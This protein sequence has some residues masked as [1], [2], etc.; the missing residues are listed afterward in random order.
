MILLFFYLDENWCGQNAVVPYNLFIVDHHI[1]ESS[2]IAVGIYVGIY[3][4]SVY[5][6]VATP[7]FPHVSFFRRKALL[8]VHHRDFP[9]VDAMMGCSCVHAIYYSHHRVSPDLSVMA[10]PTLV[11]DHYDTTCR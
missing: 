2:V 5:L 11:V 10:S 7:L 9:L 6:L 4:L 8:A 3:V 1:L